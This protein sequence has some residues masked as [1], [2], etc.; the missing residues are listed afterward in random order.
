MVGFSLLNGLGDCS[1]DNDD[2]DDGDDECN[3]L[4]SEFE[5]VCELMNGDDSDGFNEA[6]RSVDG[7]E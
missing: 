6:G 2:I 3:E 4:L 5:I 7:F 1:V